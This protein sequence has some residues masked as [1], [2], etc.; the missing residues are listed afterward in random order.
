MSSTIV[1]F[2]LRPL[3]GVKRARKINTDAVMRAVAHWEWAASSIR[4][5]L[6]NDLPMT[7]VVLREEAVRELTAC[8]EFLERAAAKLEADALPL[9]GEIA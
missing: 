8:A 6:T 3:P 2:P 7:G 4:E 5:S 9:S 1:P